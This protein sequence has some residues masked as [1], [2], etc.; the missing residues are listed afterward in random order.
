[1]PRQLGCQ[2]YEHVE[3]NHLCMTDNKFNQGNSQQTRVVY[4]EGIICSGVN[5]E[6][7]LS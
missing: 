2:A 5:L 6:S 1:M 4:E 7:L 3:K